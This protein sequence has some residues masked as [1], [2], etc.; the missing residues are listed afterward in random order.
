MHVR[1]V[2]TVLLLCALP[3]A[4]FCPGEKVH[5]QPT[6]PGKGPG[7]KDQV[8]GGPTGLWVLNALR[9]QT[10]EAFG[11]AGMGSEGQS[12]QEHSLSKVP[13]RKESGGV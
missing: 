13:G 11:T 9:I 2:F 4:C 1:V 10:R 7:E 12:T 8:R 6:C 3:R 5:T